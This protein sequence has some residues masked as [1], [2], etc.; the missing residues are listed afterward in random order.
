MVGF[1]GGSHGEESACNAGDP[2]FDP[3]VGKIIIVPY[4]GVTRI[5]YLTVGKLFKTNVCEML[6][7]MAGTCTH[8]I[9]TSSDHWA[10]LMAQWAKNHLQCWRYR[11]RGFSLWAGKIPWRRKWQPTP[12][13]L[14]GESHGQGRL[15]GY[16]PKDRKESD[17]TERLCTQWPLL[18]LISPSSHHDLLHLECNFFMRIDASSL[19]N[20]CI[21][22]A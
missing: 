18:L 22:L 20:L 12:V 21:L 5:K 13:F 8:Y 17:T 1:R 10:F 14:T 19:L 16:T 7:I 4:R 11:S 9:W 3:W 15:V 6:G 2:A